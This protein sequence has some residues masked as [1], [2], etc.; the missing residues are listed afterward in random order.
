MNKLKHIYDEISKRGVSKLDVNNLEKTYGEFITNKEN[1][2]INMFTKTVSDI[3]KQVVLKAINLKLK[4]LDSLKG[5]VTLSTITKNIMDLNDL[6]IDIKSFLLDKEIDTD[7]INDCLNGHGMSTYTDEK[8][9]VSIVDN[10]TEDVFK[11]H[12]D[13]LFSI[14]DSEELKNLLKEY[15]DLDDK[16]SLF[17]TEF[18]NLIIFITNIL[19]NINLLTKK[20]ENYKNNISKYITISKTELED[21]FDKEKKYLTMSNYK[22]NLLSIKIGILLFKK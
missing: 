4:E 9:L 3:G 15:N 12:L 10:R 21:T 5:E 16:S 11:K 14:N 22:A 7:L 19:D 17:F 1:V 6:I 2:H 13:V 20:Y 18:T 8:E